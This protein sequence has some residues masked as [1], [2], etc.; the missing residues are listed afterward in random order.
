MEMNI[1]IMQVIDLLSSEL[2]HGNISMSAS[3]SN[4]NS[5]F[6]LNFFMI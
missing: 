4:T 2:S 3:R 1:T 6:G 5:H